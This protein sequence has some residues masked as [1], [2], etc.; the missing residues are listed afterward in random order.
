MLTEKQIQE[1]LALLLS[2]SLNTGVLGRNLSGLFPV[3]VKT[4]ARWL[5]AARGEYAAPRMYHS[6]VAPIVRTINALNHLDKTTNA[7]H[8]I[9]RI[10]SPSKRL[11]ALKALAASV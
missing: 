2:F 11:D 5:A 9:R 10:S 1:F 7:Y 4:M 3:S 6:R 8:E